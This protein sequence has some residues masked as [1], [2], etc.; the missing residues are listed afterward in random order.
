MHDAAARL[1]GAGSYCGRVRG[2]WAAAEEPKQRRPALEETPCRGFRITSLSGEFTVQR[3]QM[4][5]AEDC[6]NR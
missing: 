4:G 1:P 3:D 2:P 6:G 5:G